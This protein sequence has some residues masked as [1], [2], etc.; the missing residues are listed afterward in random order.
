M[1]EQFPPGTRVEKLDPAS[2][3]MKSGTVMDI[4][5]DPSQLHDKQA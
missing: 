4:P 5:L 2:N 1:A 3:M